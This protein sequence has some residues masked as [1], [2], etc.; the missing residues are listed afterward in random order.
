VSVLGRIA[1]DRPHSKHTSGSESGVRRGVSV[2]LVVFAI[3]RVVTLLMAYAISAVSGLSLT[4]VLTRWDGGW[5]LAVVQRGY[6]DAV[7]EGLGVQAQ[8]TIAFFPGY[9]LMIKAASSLT[10]ISPAFTG[11]VI[12]TLTGAAAS[13]VLW[14]LAARVTDVKSADRT[15]VLFC[16]FPAAFVLSM[17]YAEAL[18]VLLVAGCLLTLMLERWA[19][20]G[21]AAAFAGLVRPNGLVLTVCCGWAAIQAIRRHGSWRPI[22]APLLAPTGT[23]AFLWY[24]YLRT[25]D[26]LAYVHT[27]KRGWDQ[28]FDFGVS[29][30][31]SA[32]AIAA[33]RRAEFYVLVIAACLIGIAVALYFLVR[34]RLPTPLLLYVVGIIGIALGSSNTTSVPRFLLTA[35]PVLIPIARQLSDNAYP[36]VVACSAA[37]MATLFWVTSQATWLTP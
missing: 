8:T 25:G 5:Y 3:S 20:A 31:Q 11:V 21:L 1:L 18:F 28:G 19:V 15:V 10:G 33:S 14:L 17:V 23:L 34:W 24:L 9:P 29:N 27:Q 6:P 26:P 37:L 2:S 7:A 32:I 30:V 16:F 12:S 4:D 13:V 36:V 35:F 22:I